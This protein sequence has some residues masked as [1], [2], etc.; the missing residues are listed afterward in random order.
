MCV[1][2]R[3]VPVHT[4]HTADTRADMHAPRREPHQR[5]PPVILMPTV[6]VGFFSWEVSSGPFRTNVFSLYCLAQI[7]PSTPWKGRI[8]V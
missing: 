3:R 6:T 2:T 8:L 4:T 5:P 1:Y 7:E